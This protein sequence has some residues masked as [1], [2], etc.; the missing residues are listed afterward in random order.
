MKARKRI[1]L[2]EYANTSYGVYKIKN[3]IL[4]RDKH[5][6]EFG[7]ATG[8]LDVRTYDFRSTISL[9]L[10]LPPLVFILNVDY[11]L[12]DLNFIPTTLGVQ[13]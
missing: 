2:R 7:L 9:S 5:R 1:H 8:D 12:Y 10:S 11:R 4:F 3:K 6:P 13:T